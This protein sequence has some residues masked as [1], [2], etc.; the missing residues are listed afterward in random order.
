MCVAP[1]RGRGLKPPVAFRWLPVRPCRPFTGAWIETR[2]HNRRK[3]RC[4]G[5]PFT[6]AWIETILEQTRIQR[7][8]CRP[9]TGAWI[10]TLTLP[11][12][13]LARK[14]R[15]FTGAWIETACRCYPEVIRCSRPFTGAWIE[16][17]LR[18]AIGIMLSV[19]PSRGRGLKQPYCQGCPHMRR[20][21]PL[22]GGVD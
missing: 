16:T 13:L 7:I 8:R 9:F 6:G 15:P 11:H 21:S 14:S 5:R 12:P 1:S 19:A 3:G 20:M 17:L 18:R 4:S 2:W 22:H 10:E